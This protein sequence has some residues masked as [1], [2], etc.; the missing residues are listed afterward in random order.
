[1]PRASTLL[2]MMATKIILGA[3]ALALAACQY[4]PHARG[5]LLREPKMDEVAGTYRVD[6]VSL[7]Q[8]LPQSEK[9]I[10]ARKDCRIE[11]SADGVVR[12]TGLPWIEETET[13]RYAFQGFRDGTVQARID[14]AGSVGSG[15]GKSR[16]FY[17]LAFTG[18]PSGMTNARLLGDSR[19]VSGFL[20]GFGDPDGGEAIRFVR[21]PAAKSTN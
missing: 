1:M 8:S 2:Q 20:F 14:S 3:V 6:F 11:I 19:A 4:D 10:E 18:L 5:Y 16:T 15:S 21:V 7:Y 9:E 13:F 12:F 17:G